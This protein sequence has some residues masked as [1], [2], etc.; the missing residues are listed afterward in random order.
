LAFPCPKIVYWN[1]SQKKSSLPGQINSKNNIFL[2][3]HEAKLIRNL[4][5]LKTDKYEMVC[6]II[7]DYKHPQNME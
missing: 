2:S 4:E 7:K 3:G 5:S 1:L 6:E